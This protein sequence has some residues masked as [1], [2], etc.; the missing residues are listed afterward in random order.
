MSEPT[1]VLDPD[2]LAPIGL[3]VP[4][5]AKVRA[6]LGVDDPAGVELPCGGREGHD[7]L[8]EYRIQWAAP[9]VPLSET[10]TLEDRNEQ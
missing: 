6:Y 7:G 9:P 5:P 2:T 10:D 3:L 1:Y 4:C 8:H